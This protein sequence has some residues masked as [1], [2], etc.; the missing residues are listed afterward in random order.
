MPGNRGCGRL[1]FIETVDFR[2]L[3]RYNGYRNALK[4]SDSLMS[5]NETENAPFQKSNRPPIKAI[6][7]STAILRYYCEDCKGYAFV[8]NGEMQCCGKRLEYQTQPC[9]LKRESEGSFRRRQPPRKI[10]KQILA[11]QNHQCLY[12]GCNLRG[13]K[14]NWDHFFCF[15]FS[16]S[17]SERN[18]VAACQ[19][20]NQIKSALLFPTVLEA[21]IYIQNRREAKGLPNYDYFGG[22]YDAI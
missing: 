14:M 19:K 2:S 18:F 5:F 16:G 15:K 4:E 17:N 20:C 7:G 3:V 10:K 21:R 6:F 8:I 22:S 11:F 12:C 1:M 13:K 9:R